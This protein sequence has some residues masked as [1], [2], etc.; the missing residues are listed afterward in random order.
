MLPLKDPSL[1]IDKCL[2]NGKWV[3]A[4]SGKTVDVTNPATGDVIARIPSMS[5]Q[6]VEDVIGHAN[7]AFRPWA[8]RSAKERSAI[9]RKWFDRHCQVVVS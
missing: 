7:A 8:R 5:A 6:E 9:L 4:Q 3:G 2:V 1:L